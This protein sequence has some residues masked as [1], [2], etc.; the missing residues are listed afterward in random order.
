VRLPRP[1]LAALGALGLLA[2]LWACDSPG[3]GPTPGP[4]AIPTATAS[5]APSATATTT[6]VPTDTPAPTAT[7]GPVRTPIGGP[8]GPELTTALAAMEAVPSEHYTVTLT[9]GPPNARYVLTGVGQY[10]AP[11]S[12][13]TTFNAVGFSTE[14]LTISDTTYIRSFGVWRKGE[15]DA[16]AF[17]LGPPPNIGRAI[18]LVTYAADAGLAGEGNETLDGAPARHFR[19]R[20]PATGAVPGV[21]AAL[22]SAGDLWV[23]PETHRYRRL[24]L[25]VG[26]G[27]ASDTGT[28][29][30]DFGA[31]GAPVTLTPPPVL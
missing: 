13:D 4:T 27:D 19:F 12:Y 6:P 1:C 31:Y 21:G 18:G 24:T 3:P 15:P 7:E 22:G 26:P 5:P 14:V 16:V 11:A 30:I 17:P 29:Q 25:N 8:A 10:Q 9:L 2:A 23:D 28:L 20:L